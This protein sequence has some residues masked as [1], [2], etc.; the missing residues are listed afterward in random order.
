MEKLIITAA[1]N[2]AETTRAQSPAVPYTPEEIAQAAA[3]ARDAGA[4]IVHVHARLADGT[5]TQDKAVYRQILDA[6]TA[7]SDLI[8]QVSTGGAVGMSAQERS[9]VIELA[10]EMATLSAG[11]VNFG[12][13]VFINH[14]EDIARFAAL[15]LKYGVV[16][17]IEVFEAGMIANAAR[18]AAQGLFRFPAHFDF[19]FGV[20]GGM[21]A[22]LRHL[23]HAIDCLPAGCTW[24]A[25]GVGRAQLPMAVCAIVLGGHVRV[26]LED[27]IYYHKGRL[28]ASSAELV[29]RIARLA[30][31]LGRDVATPDEARALLGISRR[32]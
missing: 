16:P 20:P 23:Q 13:G 11:S 21:P 30:G 3:E 31:E 18:L 5:A 17:E 32:P 14:P 22:E 29:E 24:T 1:V 26:G 10:P 6:V 27:N 12:D 25:A 9:A 2:G 7:R 19:V 15:M 4:A 28:A 8:V